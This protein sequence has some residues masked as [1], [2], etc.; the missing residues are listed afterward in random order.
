MLLVVGGQCGNIGKTSVVTGLLRRLPEAGWHTVKLSWSPHADEPYS[1]SE[2]YVPNSRTDMGRCLAAGALR[3]Y[4]LRVK[5][6]ATAWTAPELEQIFGCPAIFE[7]DLHPPPVTPDLYLFVTDCSSPVIGEGA[8]QALDRADA[9][10][11]VDCGG[12]LP[13]VSSLPADKPRFHVCPSQYTSDA[14]VKFVQNR[15]WP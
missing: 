15:L 9:I 14:L 5:D 13:A 3:S 6:A 1:L 12:P 8:R 11:V 2:E 4:L 10:V 7:T